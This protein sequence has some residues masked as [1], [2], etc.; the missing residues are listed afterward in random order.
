MSR[1]KRSQA[2]RPIPAGHH[3]IEPWIIS[4]NSAQLLD[5]MAR[6]FGAQETAR[7]PNDDG[8]IGHAEARI[9]DSVVLMFDAKPDWPM[10]PAFVRLY[11]DD[12]D[13]VYRQALAAGAVSI[14]EPT[15]LFFGD[16]VGR[17]RDPFDNIWWI[18][19]HVEDV[20]PSE[21][22]RRAGEKKYLD[23]MQAVQ[24]SL[25]REMSQRP[26]A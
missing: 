14:T 4:R 26:P 16:R 8:T 6:A 25:I 23:A 17:V 7:V 19:T 5:F 21:L 18:Q 1:D 13:A 9:G 2:V 15:T 3:A 11:V 10:T 22:Q 12:C 24:S 20:D